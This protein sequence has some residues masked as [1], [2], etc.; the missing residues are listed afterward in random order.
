M[1]FVE[2]LEDGICCIGFGWWL[3]LFASI[4]ELSYSI[5]E[6]L[7]GILSVVGVIV[8]FIV[9]H[10]WEDAY[11]DY[12]GFKIFTLMLLFVTILGYFINL[13]IDSGGSILAVI[14]P[15]ITSFIIS[16]GI[17]ML[18]WDKLEYDVPDYVITTIIGLICAIVW[19]IAFGWQQVVSV[20]RSVPV[21]I[22]IAAIIVT[23]YVCHKIWEEAYSHLDEGRAFIKFGI[24]WFILIFFIS[25][26]ID[27]SFIPY[28]DRG[29]LFWFSSLLLNLPGTCILVGLGAKRLK[30]A[31]DEFPYTV[32]GHAKN[33]IYFGIFWLI[34]W[35]ISSIIIG[36][37]TPDPGVV[38]FVFLISVTILGAITIIII[39]RRLSK[40]NGE[41]LEIYGAT[42]STVRYGSFSIGN[43]NDVPEHAVCPYCSLN[44]RESFYN[45]GGVVKCPNCGTFYH[46]DCFRYGCGNPACKFRNT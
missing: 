32:K 1:S 11:C 41:G 27:L 2:D 39:G 4:N 40:A 12:N 16:G 36:S 17:S 21:L 20:L 10:Y 8:G 29:I 44:I 19:A 6:T 35:L 15:T 45:F 25:L 31:T 5:D 30:S 3:L 13:C 46:T 14:L 24:A 9:L 43:I 37:N 23:I 26:I 38:F 7:A 28:Y 18:I 34:F 22:I 42:P 33:I